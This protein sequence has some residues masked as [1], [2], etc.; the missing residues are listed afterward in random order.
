MELASAP[1][2]DTP[3]PASVLAIAAGRATRM[4]WRNDLGGLTIAIDGDDPLVAKWSPPGGPALAGEAERMRWLATRHPAPLVREHVVVDDGE[5]LVT[6]ALPGDGAVANRWL[7]DPETAV[8]AI[9]EGLRRLHALPTDDCPWTWLPADRISSARAHGSI[10]P[11]PLEHAPSIDH[12]VVGHG[13]A[14]APNTLLDDAGAFLATVDVGRLGLAD[15]WSDLAV[16]TM[17]LEWNYGPGFEPAFWQ[18][19]GMEPDVERVAYYRALWDV[20]D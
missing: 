7:T 18:A 3:V 11:T 5:L 20:A 13:D 6:E 8:R 16:A 9:A 4:L 15:R 10:V 2:A 1:P 19:Y 17:S 12:L 14:C